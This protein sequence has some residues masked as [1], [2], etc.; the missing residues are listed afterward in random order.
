MIMCGSR[1]CTGAKSRY[2]PIEGELL[3]VAWAL[4]KTAY[5]TLGS[6]KL[7]LLVDHK[8]LIGLLNTRELGDVDPMWPRCTPSLKATKMD[9]FHPAYSWSN[10]QEPGCPL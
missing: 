6:E 10:Q 1:F 3:A 4:Q 5:F 9:I 8:P 7:L 2:H